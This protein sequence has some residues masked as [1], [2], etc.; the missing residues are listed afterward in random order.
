MIEFILSSFDQLHAIAIL[1]IHLEQA[2]L[3][4]GVW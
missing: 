4:D 2:M 3:N 1:G